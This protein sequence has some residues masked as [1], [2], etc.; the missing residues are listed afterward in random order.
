MTNSKNKIYDEIYLEIELIKLMTANPS[1]EVASELFN[2]FVKHKIKRTKISL[3]LEDY[4][5]NFFLDLDNRSLVEK[6][7]AVIKKI[8]RPSYEHKH[9]AMNVLTWESVLSG[10]EISE[11]YKETA[12]IFNTNYEKIRQA[13]ERKNHDFGRKELCRIGLDVFIFMNN[14]SLSSKDEKNVEL[15]L[16]EPI[17]EQIHKDEIHLKNKYKDL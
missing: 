10:L 9:I 6:T 11:A 8:G 12:K 5:N 17:L 13:F 3:E 14:Y 2:L 15:I 1:D 16:N 4:I 7:L